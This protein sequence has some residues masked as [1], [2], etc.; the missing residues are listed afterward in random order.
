MNFLIFLLEFWMKSLDFS[1]I[2]HWTEFWHFYDSQKNVRI[3]K[4][5]RWWQPFDFNDYSWA[6]TKTY[7]LFFTDWK[8]YNRLCYKPVSFISFIQ[9]D[10]IK[11]KSPLT[12][13]L[14]RQHFA[15]LTALCPSLSIF[16]HAKNT[17]PLS[18]K[19]ATMR[20]ELQFQPI[21]Q[22]PIQRTQKKEPTLFHGDISMRHPG[23][24]RSC[25]FL[26]GRPFGE[27]SMRSSLILCHSDR[28]LWTVN[29]QSVVD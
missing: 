29:C 26:K 23:P 9:Y 11:T 7:R 28:G 3:D 8:N 6:P 1:H 19:K 5:Q 4:Q 20:T 27:S 24:T 17:P 25:T 18:P 14:H 22:A 16:L 2:L 10:I 15:N 13:F 12:Q 21:D